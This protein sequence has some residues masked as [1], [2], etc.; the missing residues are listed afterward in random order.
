MK[1][2]VLL[3][4]ALAGF[5]CERK[6]DKPVPDTVAVTLAPAEVSADAGGTRATALVMERRAPLEGIT[7]SFQVQLVATTGANPS[8]AAVTAVTDV[9]GTASVDL[10]GLT[11][12]GDGEVVATAMR[13]MSD[14][15][16][17]PY[18]D[19][20]AQPIAGRARLA[21]F[22]GEAA[23]IATS[24][25]DGQVDLDVKDW[26]EV[27]HVVRDQ[28]GNRTDDL[29]EVATNHPGATI[30]GSR[31]VGLNAAGTW[32][33]AV[34]VVGR[35]QI[36]DSESLI[37]GAGTAKTIDVVLSKY[38]TDAYSQPDAIPAV[39]VSLT[40]R[41]A[42]GNVI[43]AP[44][45]AACGISPASG[46]AVTPVTLAIDPLVVK[47]TFPV[48]CSF[49]DG[50]NVVSDT[51]TLTVV[52]LRPPVVTIVAPADGTHY[53][54]N[55]DFTVSVRGQDVI[56]V[57][58]LTAQVVGLGMSETQ[59][60]IVASLARDTTVS[61]GFTTPGASA[62]GGT[63]TIYGLGADGSGNLQNASP[64]TIVV[65][66]F[67]IL[68][69]NLAPELVAEDGQLSGSAAIAADP[70]SAAAM[71]ALYIADPA[72]GT[73][74]RVVYDRAAKSATISAFKTGLGGVRGVEWDAAG[75]VLYASVGTAVRR[76]DRAGTEITPSFSPVGAAELQHLVFGIGGFLYVT[77]AG[78]SVYRIDVANGNT[79]VFASPATGR[80]PAGAPALSAPV[81]IEF[82]GAA[83]MF[84][85]DTNNDNVYEAK[86]ANANGVADSLL[87]FMTGGAGSPNPDVPLGLAYT[88][89]AVN[90][91]NELLSAQLGNRS[92]Y[93]AERDGGDAGVLSD[94]W[95]FLLQSAN[96]SPVD[97]AIH[98]N[99]RAYV[100]FT[101][102]G[103]MTA[104]VVELS[105]L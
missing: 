36:Y 13:E 104:H 101:G 18:Q 7:V 99:G 32:E 46:G 12:A 59:T 53:P 48:T 88:G 79:N 30:L 3:V 20:A 40:V 44:A 50:A 77:D 17:E 86:D 103:G 87:E 31:I 91:P 52:D 4:A 98:A 27:G 70:Q 56:A 83:S 11:L 105:G 43:A 15:A 89:A 8:Y 5:G 28:H 22:P 35:P 68:A 85:G 49:M 71:P 38:T 80:T 95:D 9:N 93:H 24:L 62:F 26:I 65:D 37:V 72:D 60:Q 63:M 1:R 92:I 100:L 102:G 61:F 19:E 34:S 67:D 57:S 21:V 14:G 58:Q 74:W 90:R 6:L 39:S 51:E 16:F 25:S 23:S 78:G 66:P 47:G 82:D 81:G 10:T 45:D 84:I 41:D 2:I 29:V 55:T 69:A 96:R 97:L 42:N 33:V 75:N 64:V 76:F 94:G 73:I 54:N